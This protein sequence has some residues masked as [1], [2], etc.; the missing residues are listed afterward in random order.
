MVSATTTPGRTEFITL[1]AGIMMVVAFAIDSMLP[2]L[3]AIAHSLGVTIPNHQQFVI[4]AFMI[5][6]GISQFFVG[7]LSDRYGRRGLMLAS[8]IG[9]SVFSLAAAIA[10]TF[11]LLLLARFAQGTAA[12]GARVLVV[13][14]VR[15]KFEGRAMAQVM[16]LASVVFMAAP[17]LAP[18]M[19]SLIIA[20]AP[21]RWIFIVLAAVGAVLWTWVFL[22][23]AES[24]HPEDR[25]PITKAQIIE[26][27]GTVLSD[28][29]SV[30]YTL[31]MTFL[32]C[33]IFG[34]LTSVQQIF[35]QIFKHPQFLP[36]GFAI[37]ASTMA[38]ASLVNSRIVMRWGMRLIGHFALTAFT[39]VAAL[40]MFVSVSGYETLAGF[41]VL[42]ALMMGCFSLAVGN[43]G[44][45]AMERVGHV[46]GTASSLQGSFS[47]IAG[48]LGG[49]LIG[50]MFNGTTLPLYLGITLA[51]F[52][53]LVAVFVAEKGKMFVSHNDHVLEDDAWHIG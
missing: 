29:Q 11:E 46:A 4:T 41:V 19:G 7:T 9:Y 23:L 39:I 15:D 3:P 21:W 32:T 49:G 2:A 25:K 47:T 13:S 52:G 45:L 28:R 35:D 42:Q 18:A 48:A 44:T 30:G 16:S 53:A 8:L 14:V 24:Q 43:F 10:P 17:I 50:Q 27:F 6:F 5:G 38:L 34:F 36:V 51:G 26:S 12:A 40:H 31:A 22:R 20:V 37:M 33:A 1:V